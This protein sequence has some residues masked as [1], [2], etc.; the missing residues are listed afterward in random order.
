MPRPRGRNFSRRS[1]GPNRSW[2]ALQSTAGDF[3]TV[4]PAT[5]VL[6]GGFTLSNPNIDETILRTVGT[7]AVRSD[8]AAASESQVGAFGMIIVTD[9]A[10]AAGAASIPG[11]ITDAADDGWFVY[12]PI[13]QRFEF[14]SAVGSNPDQ[15]TQYHFDSKAKRKFAEGQQVAVMCE[16]DGASFGLSI[17]FVLR[18]LSQ[19]TGT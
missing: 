10:A 17:A 12:V 18:L 16:N 3:V 9:L 2:A 5:K 1:S 11:P 4:A 13:V 14:A 19:V 8:Q 15:A 7:L 6:L